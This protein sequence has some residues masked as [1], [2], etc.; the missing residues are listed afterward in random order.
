MGDKTGIQW[1]DATWNPVRGCSRVSAGC[2]HCYA[3][4]LAARFSGP[5]KAYEGLIM[6]T[7]AGPRWSN[8]IKLVPEA[9][10]LPLRW[11]RPRRIFVNSMSDL[12]HEDVPDS[13]VAQV[14]GVMEQAPR[15]TFQVLTK[16]P[17]RMLELLERP[18]WRV[19]LPNVWLGVS[20]ENRAA[21]PRIEY[22][23]QTPAALRFLSV[24]PLIE[25]L[26]M[27][28]LRGIDWVIIGGES[29]AGARPFNLAWARDLIRQCR[30][31]EVAPFMKQVGAVPTMDE[32]L[33]R[34]TFPT[35]LLTPRTR[36]RVPVGCVGLSFSD[37]KGADLDELPK[38]LRVREYPVGAL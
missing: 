28:D 14:F 31:A 5:R 34:N 23:R 15:H 13:F 7:T 16:R 1:T 36:D 35:P 20:V 38:D 4:A 11:R 19:A 3:E 32:S 10:D 17:Q 18:V 24:E 30:A 9:L 25:D 2:E 12:F 26:G 6:Q 21:L 37:P 29:G 27:I 8:A 22:L 33:W